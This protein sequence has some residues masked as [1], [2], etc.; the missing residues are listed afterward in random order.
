MFPQIVVE[1][2]ANSPRWPLKSGDG[3]LLTLQYPHHII[4]IEAVKTCQRRPP[5]F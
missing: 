5:E 3:V 1:L 2:A 4:H